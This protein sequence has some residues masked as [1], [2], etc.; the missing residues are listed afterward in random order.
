MKALQE[1]E[2]I[3]KID[4]NFPY[5]DHA[6]CL[7]LID[8][9]ISISPNAVFAVVEEICRIPDEDRE[10]TSF[11]FLNDLLKTIDKKFEHPLKDLV[12]KIA[13]RMLQQEETPVEEAALNLERVRKYPMQYS[14]MNILYY[15]CF[16]DEGKLDQVW[17]SIIKEW[18][19]A[20]M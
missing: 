11:L 1:L 6:Q 14:A 16:D 18:D 9:A 19:D 7:K 10:N 12:F 5:H 17:D 4:S 13:K 8:E 15:S 3:D 20:L 2:F